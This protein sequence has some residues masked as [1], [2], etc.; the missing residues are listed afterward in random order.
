MVQHLLNRAHAAD[1]YRKRTGRMHPHW[2]NGTLAAAARMV[3][4]EARLPAE[5]FLSDSRFFAAL[6]AVIDGVLIWRARV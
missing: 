1:C 6:G 5:P 2:G 4:R 3:D